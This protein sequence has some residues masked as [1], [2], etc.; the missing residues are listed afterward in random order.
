MFFSQK[1]FSFD[2]SSLVNYDQS[3]PDKSIGLKG[4][5]WV[6]NFHVGRGF[7]DSRAT[8]TGI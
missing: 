6:K 8:E 4:S 2:P 5:E 3:Q 7:H 1:T